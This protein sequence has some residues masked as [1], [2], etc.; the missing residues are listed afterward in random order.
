[1]IDLTADIRTALR[2][3]MRRPTLPFTVV[4]TLT[5]GLGAAIAVF[6]VAWAVVWRPLDVPQ[7]QRLVWIE[8][9]SATEADGSSPGAALT[10]Q[11]E[12]LTLDG[13]AAIRPVAGVLADDRGTD[14]LAG[15]LV[16]APIFD[17]LGLRP[18]LGRAFGP[19]EDAPGTACAAARA[20]RLAG[21]IRRRPG[22]HRPT[23]RP[24][25]TR[26]HDHRRAARQ[27]RHTRAW[28]RLVGAACTRTV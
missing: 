25:W 12:A 20:P 6:A 13:L 5:A 9:Q 26:R 4:A 16:T 8:S 23:G 22:H 19:S 17:V 15:A 2:Q 10:W 24:R 27:G 11:D 18:V 14:R 28:R 1:M 7:P 21:A 3:W